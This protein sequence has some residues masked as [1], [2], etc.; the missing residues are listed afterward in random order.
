MRRIAVIALAAAMLLLCV[1]YGF[2][3]ETDSSVQ[4]DMIPVL[5]G[6]VSE[7]TEEGMMI[8]TAEQGEVFVVIGEETVVESTREIDCG[9]Y[10][11]VEYDGSMT[12]SLP[13]QIAAQKIG[14]YAVEGY[15]LERLPESNMVMLN[16]E[17]QGEVLVRLA[18]D[19]EDN[20]CEYMTVYYN[21]MVMTSLPPQIGA[22]F[23]WP[24]YSVQ[25]PITEIA[26]GYIMIGEGMEAY[27]VN[28][29]AE[30]L[31]EG[32]EAGAVVRVFY[33]GMMSRS[34]PAQITAMEIVRISR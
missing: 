14:M 4:T 20:G 12:F 8:N 28:C 21:G 31:P 9:D 30:Q 19:W 2:A 15:V 5:S 7:I 3:E 27:Q 33:N 10:V 17:E 23:I 18:E 34:I 22:D 6:V 16:T 25:G 32:I 29:T 11:H 24:G 13:P 1:A 26:D